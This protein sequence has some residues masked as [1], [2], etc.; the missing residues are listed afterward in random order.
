[1]REVAGFNWPEA[2]RRLLRLLERRPGVAAA[3][4]TGEE[5]VDQRQPRYSHE[6]SAEG[7][8]GRAQQDAADQQPGEKNR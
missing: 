7:D 4:Y 2:H 3:G 5:C 1:M 6:H 8:L